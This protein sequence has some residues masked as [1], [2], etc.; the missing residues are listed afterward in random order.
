MNVL[1]ELKFLRVNFCLQDFKMKSR[2]KLGNITVSLFVF[3]SRTGTKQ[4]A[5]KHKLA[6][7]LVRATVYKQVKVNN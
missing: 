5:V 3:F 2:K 7:R 6:V 1:I 4:M